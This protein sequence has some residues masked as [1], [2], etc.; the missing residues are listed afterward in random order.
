MKWL[1]EFPSTNARIFVTIVMAFLFT[2]TVAVGE[3]VGHP[4]PQSTQITVYSFLT[5]WAGLDVAQF[6]IK[7]DSYAPS[8][9]A[10]PDIE[11]RAANPASTKPPEVRSA[12]GGP[13]VV[14]LREHLEKRPILTTG[15]AGT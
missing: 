4:I 11:D 2:T 10:P 5:V 9:P 6:K 14:A 13:V 3:I 1:A 15:E 7:R 12:D 8:P